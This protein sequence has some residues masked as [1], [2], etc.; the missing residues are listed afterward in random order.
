MGTPQRIKHWHALEG[1]LTKI[2]DDR[3]P[4]R[5]NNLL[6]ISR[7]A[8]SAKICPRRQR[9][10]VN[11]FTNVDVA[12]QSAK[13][14]ALRE[15]VRRA[16][17]VVLKVDGAKLR[18]VITQRVALLI[19]VDDTK[20]RHP[21]DTIGYGVAVVAH[22]DEHLAPLDHDEFDLVAL[23]NRVPAGTA[24]VVL[25]HVPQFV[26]KVPGG[27]RH[28]VVTGHCFKQGEVSR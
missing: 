1:S 21:V 17:V 23:A 8:L 22:A 25:R 15:R 16:Q 4:V 11:G 19:T 24:H 12:P 27:T 6:G 9:W 2:E 28:V 13:S 10:I 14:D 3:I 7:D 5:G 26:L 18:V 20:L